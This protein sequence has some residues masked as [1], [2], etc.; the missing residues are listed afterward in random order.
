MIFRLVFCP[1]QNMVKEEPLSAVTFGTIRENLYTD[2]RDTKDN[3]KGG[4]VCNNLDVIREA[5]NIFFII[6]S[7]QA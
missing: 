1:L 5:D 7:T 6:F 4:R 3:V 2:V